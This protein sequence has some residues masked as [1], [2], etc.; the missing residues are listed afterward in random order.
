MDRID[1]KERERG[2]NGEEERGSATR[3]S[4]GQEW[5]ERK[6]GVRV[7]RSGKE[8]GPKEGRSGKGALCPSLSKAHMGTPHL[9]KSTNRASLRGCH[10]HLLQ[11]L[12]LRRRRMHLGRQGREFQDQRRPNK[13]TAAGARA[14]RS[15]L[16]S[17]KDRLLP[18]FSPVLTAAHS[19]S[20]SLPH[21]GSHHQRLVLRDQQ[22][23]ARY[24][25]TLTMGTTSA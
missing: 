2:E 25:L 21:N 24:V 20:P 15:R 13:A 7:G 12:K 6:L 16:G 10:R 1:R 9:A 4:R 14:P 8:K 3:P 11:F 5:K 23:L 18:L 17:N 22:L 19:T